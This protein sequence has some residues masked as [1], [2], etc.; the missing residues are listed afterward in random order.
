MAQKRG[1]LKT[2]VDT[3]NLVTDIGL[4][5]FAALMAGGNGSPTVGGDSLTSVD[6]LTASASVMKI[7]QQKAPTAPAAGDTALEGTIDRTWTIPLAGLTV[8]YPA[9]GKVNFGALLPQIDVLNTK[10]LTEEGLFNVN[11]RLIARTTFSKLKTS[12]FALQFDHTLT[13]VR[14]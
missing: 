8:T 4:D 3:S 12:S 11:G 13:I 6:I 14:A 5:A 10:T 1:I 9:A 7:T 2:V